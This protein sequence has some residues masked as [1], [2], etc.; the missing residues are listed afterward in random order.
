MTYPH[1]HIAKIKYPDC[2]RCEGTGTVYDSFHFGLIDDT[3]SPCPDC[4]KKYRE[5]DE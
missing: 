1:V 2:E 4:E 3:G 5:S